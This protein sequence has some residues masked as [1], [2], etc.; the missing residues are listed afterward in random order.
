MTGVDPAH[1]RQVMGQYPTGVTV[2][3]AA[4]S[5]E[6]LAMVVGT[7]SSVSLDPPLV[8][9]LATR[10]SG[11]WTAIRAAGE[12]FC[13]NILSEDQHEVCGAIATRWEKRLDGIGHSRSPGGQPVIHGAVAY[14]DCTIDSIV[15]SGDHDIVIG[16]VES[17][18]V[19]STAYPL[20]FFRGGYGAFQP[21]TMTTQ[22][23]AIRS[24]LSA[25]TPCRGV[26]EQLADELGGEVTV[27]LRDGEQLVLAAAAGRSQSPTVPTRVGLRL[28]LAPP[29]GPVFAAFGDPEAERAWLATPSL[30]RADPAASRAL[31]ERVR[32]DGYAIAFGQNA[33]EADPEVSARIAQRN[34]GARAEEL[35]R[36]VDIL[37]ANY[38]RDLV[39]GEMA[40]LR[41]VNA[42]VRGAGGRLAFGLTGWGPVEPVGATEVARHVQAVLAAAARC[43]AILA[44]PARSDPARE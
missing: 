6:P 19:L 29:F 12:R 9:F 24:Q 31:L 3:T 28:P 11:A 2:I 1:Y 32:A 17:L 18:K 25:V 34:P 42:P 14:V 35:A 27:L 22:D 16:A 26:L 44:A 43:T 15:P 41:Y 13:V 23:A 21:S 20:I 8:C 7:F 40:E 36:A 37:A 10:G 5:T 33:G 39:P 4:G 30:T 38:N